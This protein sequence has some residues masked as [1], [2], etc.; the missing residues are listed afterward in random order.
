MSDRVD[1]L[2]APERLRES[3]NEREEPAR[4]TAAPAREEDLVAL[5]RRLE[6]LAGRFQGPGAGALVALLAR[7]R[8]VADRLSAAGAGAEETTELSAEI[9]ELLGHVEQLAEA[10]ELSGRRPGNR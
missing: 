1:D 8:T 9:C 3:W 4:P 7:L 6:G 2:F 10:A 5:A